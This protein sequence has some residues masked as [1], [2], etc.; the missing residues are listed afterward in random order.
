MK[1]HGLQDGGDRPLRWHGGRSRRT[2]VWC[3]FVGGVLAP[4]TRIG[5][6]LP[7]F[8]L[9][10]PLFAVSSTLSEEEK[11]KKIKIH[12]LHYRF[13]IS[14]WFTVRFAGQTEYRWWP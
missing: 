4:G 6:L 14:V 8:N 5:A 2:R 9:H 1:P 11:E 12:E 10:L 3:G 7:A 13:L